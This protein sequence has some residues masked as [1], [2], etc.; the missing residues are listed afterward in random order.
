[1]YAVTGYPQKQAA[2]ISSAMAGS[3]GSGLGFLMGR[4]LQMPFLDRLFQ[5]ANFQAGY[6]QDLDLYVNGDRDFPDERAGSNDSDEDNFVTSDGSWDYF[7]RL[8]FKYLLP[9]GRR[10]M[11]GPLWAG[12][13]VCGDIRHSDSAIRRRFTMRRNIG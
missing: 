6:F 9:M 8:R 3:K 7:F 5:D 12:S 1:V 4:D 2:L 10:P 11:P 13:G